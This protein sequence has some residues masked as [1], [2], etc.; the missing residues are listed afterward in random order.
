MQIIKKPVLNAFNFCRFTAYEDLIFKL[1]SEKVTSG[2][3]YRYYNAFA[4]FEV[5][6]LLWIYLLWKNLGGREK[7]DSETSRSIVSHNKLCQN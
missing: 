5:I 6:E 1:C 2:L 7:S 3:I 4:D